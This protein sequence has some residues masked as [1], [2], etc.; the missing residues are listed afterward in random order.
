MNKELILERIQILCDKQNISLNIAFKESGVGKNFKSNFKTSNPSIGKLT[1]LANYFNVP[2]DYLLG[3]TDEIKK[4]P[5]IK[6]SKLL[7]NSLS[8]QEWNL[9]NAYRAQ[10]E[11]QLA[12]NRLLG[13]EQSDT[14]YVY[15]AARSD[16]NRS[17]TI[18]RISKQELE[19]LENAPETD[20]DLM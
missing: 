8:A 19:K 17:D 5:D 15:T 20:E 16:D 9:L 6:P 1:M 13:I 14:V 7:K 10:P 18:T 4:E 2:V 12:V 11:L 3:K